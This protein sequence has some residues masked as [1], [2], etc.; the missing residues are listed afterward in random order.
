ML[1]ITISP[2]PYEKLAAQLPSDVLTFHLP[3]I[4]SLCQACFEQVEYHKEGSAQFP[5]TNGY[6]TYDCLSGAISNYQLVPVLCLG[7]ISKKWAAAVA[8][9]SSPSFHTSSWASLLIRYNWEF[10]RGMWKTRNQIVH[11]ATV[12]EQTNVILRDLHQKV[13]HYYQKFQLEP[14][15]LLP[16][17]HHLFHRCTLDQCLTHSYDHITCWLK[18]VKEAEQ[19]LAQHIHQQQALSA[20]FSPP[21]RSRS[22]SSHDSTYQPSNTSFTTS[23]LTLATENTTLSSLDDDTTSLSSMSTIA[24]F[25]NSSSSSSTQHS[26]TTYSSS[27]HSYPYYYNP[28]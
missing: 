25:Q 28:P 24:T 17:H 6:S 7:R 13:H 4:P 12:E 15:F 5:A 1:K 8:L 26:S 21:P 20:L 23:S 11:G 3:D 22:N 2:F 14:S 16:R 18:L 9:Y 27:V 10:I 19:V